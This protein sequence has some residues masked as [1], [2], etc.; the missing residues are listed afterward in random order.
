MAERLAEE[1]DAAAL[2]GAAEHLT[3]RLL[4]PGVR[5]GNDQLHAAQA[6][7]DKSAQEAAPERLGLGLADVERDH[8]AVAGLVDAVG[9]HQCFAD[10]TAA[11]ADLLDLRVQPQVRVAALE[12]PVAE[13]VDLLVE[14][15]ADP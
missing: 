7:L 13:D 12:R 15:L 1:V 10:D 14:A 8:L 5:V 9:E 4:Q 3:D 2:P 11:V 6:T